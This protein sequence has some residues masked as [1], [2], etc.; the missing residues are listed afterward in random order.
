MRP[1][2]LL[3]HDCMPPV[4]PALSPPPRQLQ[5]RLRRR[6][7]RV[8]AMNRATARPVLTALALAIAT[9]L[10]HHGLAAEIPSGLVAHYPLDKDASDASGKGHHATSHGAKPAAEGKLGGAFAFDGSSTFVTIPAGVTHGLS[11]F[12]LALWAKTGQSK[13]APRKEFWRNPTLLGVATA[14]PGSRDLAIVAEDGRVA[15]H[16]GLK[17]GRDTCFFTDA[18]IADDKWHH[19]AITNGGSRILFYVDGRLA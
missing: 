10:L 2:R 7:P 19:L 8:H 11:E 4:A 3:A 18:R 9:I 5:H 15:Y 1:Q 17:E 12:T 16:H 6:L 14:A 13:A